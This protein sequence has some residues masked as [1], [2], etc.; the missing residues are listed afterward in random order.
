MK[1][2]LSFRATVAL[3]FFAGAFAGSIFAKP[4]NDKS[5]PALLL[6]INAPPMWD[7]LREADVIDAFHQRVVT[8]LQKAGFDGEIGE[9]DAFKEPDPAIP[10]IEIK[11]MEWRPERAGSI[12]CTFSANL[13]TADKNQNLGIFTGTAPQWMTTASH[14]WE[15]RRGLDDSA[16]RALENLVRKLRSEEFLPPA[17]KDL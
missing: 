1:H 11:L 10:A 7:S 6:A 9:F 3:L 17:K 13:K 8:K 15:L 14:T 12:V 4:A 5:S 16:N 2:F